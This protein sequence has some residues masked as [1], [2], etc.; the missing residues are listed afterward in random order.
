MTHE[1]ETERLLFRA[2][3]TNDISHLANLESDTDVKQFFP[4]GV[5]T[6]KRTQDMIKRFIACYE[7][8]G[9]PCFL[10]F[11]R[12]SQEFIGRAGF[13][14]TEQGEVEIGYVLHKKFWG[15][16]YAVEAVKCLLKYANKNIKTANIIAYATSDNIN[17][18]RVMEKCG[19]HYYKTDIVQG[20][21][22]RFYKIS[23][24]N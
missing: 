11:D 24:Y 14:M 6:R 18:F 2:L 16:G 12:Q 7:E 15:K 8:K 3:K 23:N 20:V 22:C 4:G 9:L 13:G 1:L 17:S 5:S 21:E 19:M 10:L